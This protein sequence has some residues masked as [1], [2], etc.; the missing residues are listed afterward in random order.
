MGNSC[1]KNAGVKLKGKDSDLYYGLTIRELGRSVSSMKNDERFLVTDVLAGALVPTSAA[2][3]SVLRKKLEAAG[4]NHASP[5]KCLAY[6]V[7]TDE[8]LVWESV[9]DDDAVDTPL[10][11]LVCDYVNG[12]DGLEVSTV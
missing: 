6:R 3:A 12:Y 8:T 9:S 1:G 7:L 2:E 10:Y 11:K 4:G 5:W